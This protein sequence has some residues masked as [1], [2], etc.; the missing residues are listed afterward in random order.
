MLKYHLYA[1]EPSDFFFLNEVWLIY[2]IV[3]VSHV[4]Q[5]DSLVHSSYFSLIREK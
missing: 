1:R 5:S 3:L 4:R 2:N